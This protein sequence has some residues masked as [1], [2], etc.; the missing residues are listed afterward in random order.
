MPVFKMSIVRTTEPEIVEFRVQDD[1]DLDTYYLRLP[2]AAQKKYR[3]I[4]SFE[5]VQLSEHSHT[6]QYLRGRGLTRM[7]QKKAW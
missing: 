7:L 1:V 4:A 6:A 5:L 3:N 2:R